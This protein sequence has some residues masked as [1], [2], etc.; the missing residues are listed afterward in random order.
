MQK[1]R[2]SGLWGGAKDHRR[3]GGSGFSFSPA[4]VTQGYDSIV[5]AIAAPTPFMPVIGVDDSHQ[6]KQALD[7]DNHAGD[8]GVVSPVS[9]VMRGESLEQVAR[10]VVRSRQQHQP[11]HQ[12]QAARAQEQW[13][14]GTE[15]SVIEPQ[16]RSY[17]LGYHDSEGDS[18]ANG[19]R[20]ASALLGVCDGE[21]EQSLASHSQL[22]PPTAGLTEFFPS[23][24]RTIPAGS[25][26]SGVD[27]R[28]SA[29][30]EVDCSEEGGS[31]MRVSIIVPDALSE[32]S[33]EALERSLQVISA[34]NRGMMNR[35]T[36][37]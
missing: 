21:M 14:R 3:E 10:D 22:V 11:H 33:R 25:S 26:D 9:R 32:M 27:R 18:D 13:D 8:D 37:Y 29:H 19:L 7:V 31:Q 6:D 35:E 36:V 16:D 34:V 17:P 28:R 1:G 12:Q 2:K 30:G 20:V 23:A 4:T 24:P 15:R 5:K